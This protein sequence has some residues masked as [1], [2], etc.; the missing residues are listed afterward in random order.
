MSDKDIIGIPS[1]LLSM[2]EEPDVS[3]MLESLQATLPEGYSCGKPPGGLGK[4]ALSLAAYLGILKHDFIGDICGEMRP[5]SS[6][7]YMWVLIRCYVLFMEIEEKLRACRNP[8][9]VQAYEGNSRLT[10]QKRLS[11]TVLALGQGDQECLGIMADVFENQRGGFMEHI[12]W[13]ELDSVTV[14]ETLVSEDD[15]PFNP[16][17]CTV[18]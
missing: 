16:D 10:Q 2:T 5:L 17:S 8:T 12:Y 7:N 4:R 6:L 9:W 13:D 3:E 14:K 1:K 11:L 15:T 18:M